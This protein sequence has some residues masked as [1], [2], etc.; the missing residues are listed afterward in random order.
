MA[1]NGPIFQMR[2]WRLRVVKPP[3]LTNRKWLEWCSHIG[4]VAFAF[5]PPSSP[6]A[7][8]FVGLYSHQKRSHV[9]TEE[10]LHVFP[11]VF[12]LLQLQRI[13]ISRG[14][15]LNYYWV[16]SIPIQCLQPCRGHCFHMFISSDDLNDRCNQ[17]GC[18]ELHSQAHSQTWR[19]AFSM[20]ISVFGCRGTEL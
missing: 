17:G 5:R 7:P 10:I 9:F 19:W 18:P 11:T 16:Q 4:G 14:F 1:L 20:G 12:W 2:K 6:Q 3:K 8:L 13:F 15:L